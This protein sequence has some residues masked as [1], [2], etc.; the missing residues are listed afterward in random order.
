M[1]KTALGSPKPFSFLISHMVLLY[2]SREI[3]TSG[4]KG[5]RRHILH[6]Q[7]FFLFLI[8]FESLKFTVVKFY[9]VGTFFFKV[10]V[11]L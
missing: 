8:H 3:R 9:N 1:C 10:Q 4:V 6:T 5:S 2:L 11:I 7:L